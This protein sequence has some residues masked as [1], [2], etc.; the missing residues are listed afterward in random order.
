MLG[1][2]KAEFLML[3]T[4]KVCSVKEIK[5]CMGEMGMGVSERAVSAVVTSGK[6]PTGR[7]RN[8]SKNKNKTE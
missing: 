2:L 8:E 4:Q 5:A 7:R 6:T 3:A 1:A